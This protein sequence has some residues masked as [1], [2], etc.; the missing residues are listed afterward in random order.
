MSVRIC[1]V[2]RFNFDNNSVLDQ[3]EFL[4]NKSQQYFRF[5]KIGICLA[6]NSIF[7][8]VK[9]FVAFKSPS[10][11]P[12]RIPIAAHNIEQEHFSSNDK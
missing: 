9:Y 7:N 6:S 5:E 11:N 2:P 3:Q 8:I 12:T 4:L 1:F 10:I